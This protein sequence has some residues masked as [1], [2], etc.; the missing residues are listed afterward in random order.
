MWATIT[1][2]TQK[3]IT[4]LINFILNSTPIGEASSLSVIEPGL[5]TF[6]STR[7]KIVCNRQQISRSVLP[8]RHVTCVKH[9]I[10][11]F[12]VLYFGVELATSRS[13]WPCGGPYNGRSVRYGLPN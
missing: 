6:R 12:D 5:I 1:D 3:S 8:N 2:F 4:I 13:L 11:V 10:Y 9:F 7:R